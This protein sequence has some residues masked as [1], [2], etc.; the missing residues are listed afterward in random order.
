MGNRAVIGFQDNLNQRNDNCIGIYLHWNG[1]R[2]SIEAFLQ[3][4]KNQEVRGGCYG[5]ARLTQIICNYFGGTLSVGVGA[6]KT[7][8]C[9]NFDNGLYWI[10]E[11]F[12]I[13]ER[14]YFKGSEQN[15]YNLNE[16]VDDIGTVNDK[17]FGANGFR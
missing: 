8:D 9:D 12:N 3:Y 2:D 13:V 15:E 17:H 5:V 6:I 11:N 4:A 14:Q 7:L 16:F 1:G 10:D